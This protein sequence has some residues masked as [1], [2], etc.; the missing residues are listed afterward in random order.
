MLVWHTQPC[1]AGNQ[2]DPT[3]SVN[4]L[5]GVLAHE[6]SETATDYDN[7]WRDS[8]G[9]EDGDKCASYYLNVQGIG[10]TSPYNA[11]FNVDFGSNGKFLIQSMWSADKQG[12][13]LK[14]SD[15]P[16]ISANALVQDATNIKFKPQEPIN[17][18]PLF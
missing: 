8:T 9:Y 16:A 10:S 15:T 11:A 2:T 14:E 1:H 18:K 17:I 3:Y 5:I 4:I 6:I 12:C 7:A 13:I